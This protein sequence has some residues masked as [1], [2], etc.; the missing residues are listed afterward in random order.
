MNDQTIRP[1]PRDSVLAPFKDPGPGAAEWLG[2]QPAPETRVGRRPASQRRVTLPRPPQTGTG[3]VDHR[4]VEAEREQP[5]GEI[6]F[7]DT[8]GPRSVAKRDGKLDPTLR[9]H[10]ASRATR[11][12]LGRA[13]PTLVLRPAPAVTVAFPPPPC[14]AGSR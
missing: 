11:G 5:A 9:C 13:H 4:R 14:R 10:H 6:L 1:R 3:G 7:A 2:D 12:G 8:V